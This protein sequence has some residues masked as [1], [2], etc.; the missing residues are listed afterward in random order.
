MEKFFSKVFF[1]CLSFFSSLSDL[2]TSV[3][4]PCNPSNIKYLPA[5]I[6]SYNNQSVL[7]FE[8]VI[9]LCDASKVT[10][11]EIE[12]IKSIKHRYKLKLIP[13]SYTLFA[14]ENKNNAAMQARGDIIFLNEAV[15]VLEQLSIEKIKKEFENKKIDILIFE[16]RLIAFR[17]KVFDIIKWP[18]LEINEDEKFIE[19][20]QEE[21]FCV[22]VIEKRGE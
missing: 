19:D 14:S 6:E 16:N 4:V 22:K 8:M 18:V 7:P 13:C 9:S 20:A 12:K 3:I 11:Q 1:F 10:E 15:F 17:K 5:I 21:G 2:T